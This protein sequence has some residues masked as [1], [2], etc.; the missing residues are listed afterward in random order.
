MG[1]V[2]SND[3]TDD[4][5]AYELP[6]DYEP[7]PNYEQAIKMYRDSIKKEDG[8][9]IIDVESNGRLTFVVL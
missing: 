6:P 3:L 4:P 8:L 1:R 5:P 2:L 9:K 7:P